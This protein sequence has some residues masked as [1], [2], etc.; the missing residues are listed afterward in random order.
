MSVDSLLKRLEELDT[1]IPQEKDVL[2]KLDLVQEQIDL[3]KML[4]KGYRIVA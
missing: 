4:P 1:L 3:M 2:I